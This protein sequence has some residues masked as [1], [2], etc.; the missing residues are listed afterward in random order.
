[1]YEWVT[2]L[3]TRLRAFQS[4]IYLTLAQEYLQVGVVSLSH[5]VLLYLTGILRKGQVIRASSY[6][7]GVTDMWVQMKRFD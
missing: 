6:Q 3:R 1:M 2:H 4:G 5:V 7:P